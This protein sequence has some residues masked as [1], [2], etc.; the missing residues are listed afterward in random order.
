MQRLLQVQKGPVDFPRRVV[1]V[2]SKGRIAAAG[3]GEW[4]LQ[5][6]TETMFEVRFKFGSDTVTGG[7][8][9]QEKEQLS[10]HLPRKVFRLT[11]E[12]CK[13][14]DQK[15]WNKQQRQLSRQTI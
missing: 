4:R 10:L 15:E 7:E 12:M 2:R 6:D 13:G 1:V 11:V 3:W 9:V 14:R 5:Q 8:K